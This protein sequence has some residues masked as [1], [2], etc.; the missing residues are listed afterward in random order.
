[1]KA[2]TR[3]NRNLPRKAISARPRT[4][5]STQVLAA[6]VA[7]QTPGARQGPVPACDLPQGWFFRLNL[8][9]F[10][11]S[12]QRPQSLPDGITAE[13]HKRQLLATNAKVL[14]D[15]Q[16]EIHK[17][18]P[19]VAVDII[20]NDFTSISEEQLSHFLMEQLGHIMLY[21][22]LLEAYQGQSVRGAVAQD[23]FNLAPK[24][25]LFRIVSREE[26]ATDKGQAVL[27]FDM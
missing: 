16:K 15:L 10:Q 3:P 7:K 25:D 5:S 6:A 9:A 27:H 23:S 11:S 20:A 17:F 8:S 18:D 13:Q 24:T 14:E 12:L 2:D 22:Q 26:V 4:F 21:S 19:K 1:M